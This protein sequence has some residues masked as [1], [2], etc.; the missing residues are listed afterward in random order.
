MEIDGTY[1]LTSAHRDQVSLVLPKEE[2]TS[3]TGRMLDLLRHGIPKGPRLLT[4]ESIYRQLLNKMKAE[5]LSEPQKR[6]TQTVELLGLARN[7]AIIRSSVKQLRNRYLV[8]VERSEQQSWRAAFRMLEEVVEEQV[9]ILG[10]NHPDT[11]RS[12]RL[13]A[14]ARGALGA[15]LEA[16]KELRRL[17]D[18]QSTWDSHS[19]DYLQTVQ[20]LAVNMGEAGFRRNAVSLLRPLLI[21][22][23]RVLG[24]SNPATLN[25]CHTL[26]R[27]LTE[28]GIYDE[29]EALLRYVVSGRGEVLGDNHPHTVRARKDLEDKR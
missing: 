3:F 6:G 2:H 22:R 14:H 29:S 9:D 17:L 18:S 5:G 21:D 1:V 25:T 24:P 4:I 26:A 28:M 10:E 15:P 7:R 23:M 13:L 20:F 11:L 8:A 19:E 27:N 12:R 16:A